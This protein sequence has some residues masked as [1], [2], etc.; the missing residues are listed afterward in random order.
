MAT[1][2][3]E[4]RDARELPGPL[5]LASAFPFVGR[6][7]ELEALQELTYWD[8]GEGRR[9]VLVGGAPGSGKTRLVREFARGAS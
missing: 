7:A 6:G 1:E 4:K 5:R 9:I 8:G 3:R 2:S